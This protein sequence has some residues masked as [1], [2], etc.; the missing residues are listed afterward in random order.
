MALQEHDISWQVLRRIV[1]EWAGAAAELAEVTPLT[2]GCINTTVKLTTSKGERAVLKF[3]QH[4][5]T[6]DLA[7]EA[8]Q[9]MFLREIGLPV[10]EV[11]A[12]HIATL[13]NPD[14]YL[15]MEYVE[16]FDLAAARR[17]CTADEYDDLQRHLAEV[18]SAMHSLTGS[19]YQRHGGDDGH[20]DSWVQFYR[21]VYDPIWN[22]VR[23]SS[24][25]PARLRKQIDKVHE[26][27]DRLIAHD[28]VPRLVHWDI[29]STNILAGQDAQG[30]WR[31]KALLDPNCKF[32]HSEAEIAYME[33]FHTITPS[34]LKAYQ[35]QHKLPEGYQRV[36]KHIY[37]LYPLINHV[38]LF[39]Q[40]Y[41]KPLAGV[42]ETVSG[43]V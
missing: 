16:G 26:R 40:D 9:L 8:S 31:V 15:L 36:R 27:L 37:Q 1:H 12:V 30:Q 23:K 43:L 10:P 6:R 35:S 14:S 22:D 38:H 18:I 5:V 2:G 42:V 33:L 39:G 3:A 24:L 29:W 34:F 25:L 17:Q 21:H 11:Y 28:D 13:Y 32:A 41:V 20:F 19:K 7:R 4:R